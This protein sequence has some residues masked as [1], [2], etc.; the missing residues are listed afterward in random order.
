MVTY[1]IP[2]QKKTVK[3]YEDGVK[4]KLLDFRFERG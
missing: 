2:E 4:I 3:A 1:R